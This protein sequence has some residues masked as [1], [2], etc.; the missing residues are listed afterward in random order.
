MIVLKNKLFINNN[1]WDRG[2]GW[3]NV[4]FFQFDLIK[5]ILN[6]FKNKIITKN[7]FLR[8][9][10]L[11][12]LAVVAGDFNLEVKKNKHNRILEEQFQKYF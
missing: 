10:G 11:T 4:Y 8:W 6:I 3:A 9:T 2:C 7:K 5:K 12:E 1:K